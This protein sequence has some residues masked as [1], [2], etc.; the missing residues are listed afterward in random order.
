MSERDL[1]EVEEIG[2]ASDD[3]VGSPDDAPAEATIASVAALI[4]RGGGFDGQVAIVGPTR[5]EGSVRGSL[6]GGG[7]LFIGDQARVE[8]R[9]ECDALECRGEIVGPVSARTRARFGAGARLDGD[10]ECPSVAFDEDAVWNGR[11][12]VGPPVEPGA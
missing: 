5:I 2:I 1:D 8:G 6:R 12:S 11:A 3:G 7:D 10:L 9:V 4:P